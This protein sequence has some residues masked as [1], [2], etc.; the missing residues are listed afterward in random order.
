[1]EF[2]KVQEKFKGKFK[3][4]DDMPEFL[5]KLVSFIERT[6]WYRISQRVNYLL[7][8][9]QDAS[10]EIIAPDNIDKGE[11]GNWRTRVNSNGDYVFEKR[12]GDT[13]VEAS[14]IAGS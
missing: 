2:L 14:K 12:V 7:K 13:W 10:N 8:R 11:A 3:K 4:G 6:F 9:T 1:M 5:N